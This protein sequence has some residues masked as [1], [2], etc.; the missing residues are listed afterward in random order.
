MDDA[1]NS[2][3]AMNA[4]M[5]KTNSGMQQTNAGMGRTNESIHKQ[6]LLI[7]LGEI[8]KD[9]NT[10]S[11]FPPTG[12]MPAGETFGK[13]A[14]PTELIQ[15]FYLWLKEVNSAQ[16]DGTGPNPDGTWPSKEVQDRKKNIKLTALEVIAGLT[17]QD[18]VD[19][20]INE[21]VT[22]TGRFE[23]TTYEFLMLRNAFID[24]ILIRESL[25]SNTMSNPGMF[26]EA[27]KYMRQL[28]S[29]S[30]LKFR[31]KIALKTIGM[32]IP[33]NNIEL[34][35]DPGAVK[36]LYTTIKDKLSQLDQMY[37]DSTDNTV[38]T[39]VDKI[40]NEIDRGIAE[41]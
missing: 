30:K 11:L 17:P 38:K 10:F 12:M 36:A 9:E 21:Q 33:D 18:K 41:N 14:T 22:A 23:S 39:R 32:A 24:G 26:E 15:V 19:Q 35:L 29:I 8:Q 40:K 31:D 16:A 20:L 5:D 25:L 4:K 13:E 37:S 2:T 1:L 3:I 6:T 34:K 28:E 27:L 7:A